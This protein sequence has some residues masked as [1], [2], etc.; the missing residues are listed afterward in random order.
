MADTFLMR[1]FLDKI[2]KNQSLIY[3]Y[4]LYIASVCFIV[5]FFPKG[6]QFKYEF[7][8]GR[9]WQY[10]NL[11]APFDFSINK[12]RMFKNNK[13]LKWIFVLQKID[14]QRKYDIPNIHVWDQNVTN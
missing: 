1:K 5:F 4:L 10:E 11:Y 12:N 6:G 7:Q 13:N 9:A 8:K 3:K 2:F 14:V